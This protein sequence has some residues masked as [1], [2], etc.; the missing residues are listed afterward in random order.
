MQRMIHF[1]GI[2]NSR[3]LGGL[4][5][6]GGKTIRSGLLLRSANLSQA[7]DE[8]LSILRD[9]YHLSR[10]IDLRTSAER[11]GKPDR[12]PDGVDYSANPIFDE[13]TAGITR[14][15]GTPTPFALPDMVSLYR[16]MVIAEP[17]Q[18][19]LH[20]TLEEI[21]SHDFDQGAVLWHCTAGK[22]RCGIVTS[23][24]LAALGVSRDEIL[25][26]YAINA[27]EFVGQADAIYRRALRSGRPESAAAAARDVFLAVPKYME[28][29]L[30]AIEEEY[31]NTTAY[32]L[33]GLH[34]PE[35]AI[36]EFQDKMLI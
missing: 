25:K 12:L 23:L 30:R 32:L 34:L 19:S 35:R 13:V 33:D 22:D 3:D 16:T 21:F 17:C 18:D 36:Y 29:A 26:D 9:R 6:A 15:D 4:P 5:A 11:K 27:D 8:D 14:E 7:T 24:V 10:V 1:N 20:K 2:I 31:T 28:A